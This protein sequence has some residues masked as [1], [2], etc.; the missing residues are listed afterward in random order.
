MTLQQQV[1]QTISTLDNGQLKEVAT[2]LSYLKFKSRRKN[3]LQNEDGKLAKLYA[4][5]ADDDQLLAEEG[6]ADYT[7]NLTTEDNK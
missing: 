1:N 6:M 5:F 2:Y 4:E 7:S 3:G